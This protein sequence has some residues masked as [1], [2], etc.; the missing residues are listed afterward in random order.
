MRPTIVEYLKEPPSALELKQILGKLNLTAR[1]ILRTK[2]AKELGIEP[3]VAEDKLI[4]AMV[5]NP[6]VIER[7][8]VVAG[9]KAAVGRP[10]EK[11]LDILPGA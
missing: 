9:D 7:P 1:D 4:A 11:I 3:E 10:P 6:L 2:E 8:I 5:N